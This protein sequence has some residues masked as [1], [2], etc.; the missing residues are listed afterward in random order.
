MD[1]YE[2]MEKRHSVRSYLDGEIGEETAAALREEI[3]A[4]NREGGLHF[5]FA[6]NEARAFGGMMAHYGSFKNVKNYVA[7]VCKKGEEEKLGYYGER[8]AL[9]AQQLGLNSCWVA[10]TF[11]KRKAACTVGKGE[12]LVCALALGY[13]ETQGVAHKSKNIGDVSNAQDAPEW[14]L[15]GVKAALLAPTAMNQQKFFFETDGGKVSAKA[16]RGFY[17][18]VDLGIAKFHFELGA[19][20]DRF[21]WED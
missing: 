13:G 19:G 11:S 4:C 3:E 12:K 21:T 16:G 8:V 7:L 9:K 1:I 20:K 10:L 5:Q 14:F 17:T 2:A 6:L 18:E 15:N